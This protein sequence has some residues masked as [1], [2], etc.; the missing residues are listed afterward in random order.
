LYSF[1]ISASETEES[2]SEDV[3]ESSEEE[4]ERMETVM[5]EG[6]EQDGSRARKAQAGNFAYPDSP[7]KRFVVTLNNNNR[8]RRKVKEEDGWFWLLLYAHRHRSILWAA[9]HIILT[10][11]NQLITGLKIWS[12]SNPDSIQSS[13]FSITGP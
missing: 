5:E 4:R 10:P 3:E 6:E 11:V 9:G 8:R 13:N 1:T 2:G 7:V 12:L